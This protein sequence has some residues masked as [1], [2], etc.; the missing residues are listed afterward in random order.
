MMCRITKIDEVNFSYYYSMLP[1][2]FYEYMEEDKGTLIFGI[3]NFGMAAGAAMIRRV[4]EDAELVWYYVNERYRGRGVGAEGL[5]RLMQLFRQSYG[6]ESISVNLYAGADEEVKRLFLGYPVEKN[7]P[8]QS[9]FRTTAGALRA[10]G[11]LG[12]GGEKSVALSDLSPEKLDSLNKALAEYG[13]D[14]V[15]LPI[16]PEEYLARQSAVFMEN[17]EPAGVLLLKKVR[18][19]I[20]ISL[21]ASF[22]NDRASVLDM[23]AF[24]VANSTRFDDAMVVSM[25]IVEPKVEKLVRFILS[26]EEGDNTGFETG[27]HIRLNLSFIDKAT[28]KAQ[29]ILA[30]WRAQ[31][32]GTAF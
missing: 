26:L 18:R 3:E 25:N 8:A 9:I 20:R 27:E 28:E 10:S 12:T 6:M 22:A 17:G 4:S 29:R 16:K 30:G 5:L 24:T 7:Y 23:I 31:Q 13:K 2:R 1:D 14:L 11:K 32:S 19:E 21:L 15:P